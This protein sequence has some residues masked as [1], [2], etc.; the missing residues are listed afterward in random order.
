LDEWLV[1]LMK[2]KSK[3]KVMKMTLEIEVEDDQICFELD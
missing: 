1:E 2:K 3:L